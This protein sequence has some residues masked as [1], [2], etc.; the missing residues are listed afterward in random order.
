M[1][2]ADSFRARIAPLR[3]HSRTLGQPRAVCS[4]VRS[5][6]RRTGPPSPARGCR[7]RGTPSRGYAEGLRSLRRAGEV[8]REPDAD[9]G[10]SNFRRSR[11]G[12]GLGDLRGVHGPNSRAMARRPPRQASAFRADPLIRHRS[13]GGHFGTLAQPTLNTR[14]RHPVNGQRRHEN[15]QIASLQLTEHGATRT[16]TR[17]GRSRVGCRSQ[18]GWREG[19]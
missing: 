4:I 12:P 11:R 8:R 17:A 14:G 1:S 5:R 7:S 6:S 19:T 16:V 2:R 10:A 9:V 15:R 3:G 13:P 18:A